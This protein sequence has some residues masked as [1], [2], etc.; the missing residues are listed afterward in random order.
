MASFELH[1]KEVFWTTFTGTVGGEFFIGFHFFL[2]V[3]LAFEVVVGSVD[4]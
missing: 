4:V 2:E 1:D 3:V